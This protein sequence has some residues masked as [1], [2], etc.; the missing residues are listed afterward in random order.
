VT[1]EW[2]MPVPKI[3]DVVL[4][5]KDY[6]TFADPTVGFVMKEPGSTTI[7][8]LT[9]TQSGYAMV[10]H[11]CHHKDDPA[12]QGDHGWQDLGAWDFAPATATIRELTAEPTSGRKSSKQ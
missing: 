4:F 6:R 7:S 5:S 10:Y 2:K 12:L 1:T 8:I 9:F 3:G 11:S